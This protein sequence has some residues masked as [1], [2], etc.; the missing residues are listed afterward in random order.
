MKKTVDAVGTKKKVSKGARK[1]T[2]KVPN[3]IN[4]FERVDKTSEEFSCKYQRKFA[5]PRDNTLT[6]QSGD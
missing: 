4:T 1:A 2:K 3:N 6:Q 5:Y